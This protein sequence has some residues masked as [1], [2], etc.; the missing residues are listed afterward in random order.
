VNVGGERP[1][2]PR[3][4]LAPPATVPTLRPK[5]G[6]AGLI[7]AFLGA[8]AL[9]FGLSHVP[10][11]RYVLYPFAMLSTWAHEMG[12]GLTALLVGGRF[13]HLELYADL[14]GVAYHAG[15][16]G[17]I[18]N[19]LVAAGGLLGPALL[20]GI[21]IILGARQRT[22]RIVSLALSLALAVSLALWVRNPFGMI[23]VAAIAAALGA[24]ARWGPDPVRVV[25]TQLLGIQLCLGSFSDFDYMFTK[26]FVR[27]GQPMT[28][29]TQAI[30]Q[31]LLLPYWFW[32]A[33]IAGLSIIIMLAA[34]WLAWV[35]PAL[36]DASTTEPSRA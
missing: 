3:E 21:I 16:G 26:G 13:S 7:G 30:A 11:G 28:S 34:F 1:R 5:G 2:P 36:K 25:V 10:W 15:S 19:A 12:H 20:G 17:R 4:R 33:L 32:G 24:I 35:R 18:A 27:D 29:D 31:S 8:V 14:G 22:A 9:S 23:I 6:R